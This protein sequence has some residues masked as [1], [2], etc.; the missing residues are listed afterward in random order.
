MTHYEAEFKRRLPGRF[1]EVPV[2][3]G[4]GGHPDNCDCPC[5]SGW[6]AVRTDGFPLTVEDEIDLFPLRPERTR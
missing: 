4:C 5:G 6:A 3:L 1:K 2:C